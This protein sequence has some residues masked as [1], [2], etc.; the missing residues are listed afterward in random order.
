MVSLFQLYLLDKRHDVVVCI[1]ENLFLT[2]FRPYFLLHC[3]G[4]RAPGDPTPCGTRPGPL[5][6]MTPGT[7]YRL[8]LHNSYPD[9]E[10]KTNMHT[11]GLHVVGDGN[12]DDVT[13]FVPGGSCLD[14]TWDILSD[15]PGGTHWY[16]PHWHTKT[17]E[18][19]SGG[20]FGMIIIDDDYSQLKPWAHPENELLLQVSKT[21]GSVLGNG[22]PD[23]VIQ[24]EVGRMYR[25]RVSCVEPAAATYDL[26]FGGGDCTVYKV[27]R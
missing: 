1:L 10:L 9:P 8:T 27:A 6:R 26:T 7:T 22:N 3:S 15:H 11:H 5:I 12:G 18:Q 4:Y 20:A 14:Y 17:T 13:R 23:E 16:H 24:V 21:G 2:L 19:T 25:L